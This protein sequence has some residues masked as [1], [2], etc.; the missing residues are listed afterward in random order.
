MD[1]KQMMAGTIQ[2]EMLENL[3]EK[4]AKPQKRK[5]PANMSRELFDLLSTANDERFEKY[6]AVNEKLQ[7]S[8]F[9]T[10]KHVKNC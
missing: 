9:A 3:P 8:K 10:T 4:Q 1:L 6:E 5:R 7:K 2:P